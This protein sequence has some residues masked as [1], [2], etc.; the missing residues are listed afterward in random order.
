MDEENGGRYIEE[1]SFL[2][3]LTTLTVLFVFKSTYERLDFILLALNIT[4]E[5]NHVKD[6]D[7]TV[8]EQVIS[9]RITA[10]IFW[11][12]WRSFMSMNAN[13]T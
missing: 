9:L 3:L 7:P 8:L 11:K 6:L 12:S 5:L 2:E 1:A 10:V 4:F 13:N